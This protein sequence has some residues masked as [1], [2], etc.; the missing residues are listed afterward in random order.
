MSRSRSPWDDVLSIVS[1][2]IFTHSMDVSMDK[3]RKT[4][5]TV[6]TGLP[7]VA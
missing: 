5:K 2:T 7:N 6:L 3:T 4:Y 1:V